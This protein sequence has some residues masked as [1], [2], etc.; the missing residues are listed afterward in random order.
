MNKK[1]EKTRQ[2]IRRTEA[3]LREYQE[4]LKTMQQKLRQQED[5]EIIAQ[6]RQMAEEGQDVINVLDTVRQLKEE[7]AKEEPVYEED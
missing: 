1:I 6:V 3:R 4:Y 7:M 2:E 5:E